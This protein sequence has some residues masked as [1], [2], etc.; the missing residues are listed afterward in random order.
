MKLFTKKLFKPLHIAGALLLLFLSAQSCKKSDNNTPI[1]TPAANITSIDGGDFVN[2]NK[3]TVSTI[4]TGLIAYWPLAGNAKD[5]SGNGNNGIQHGTTATA[6]H[7][8][9]AG[10]A[11]SFNG[12]SSYISVNDTAAPQL[13]NTSFSLNAWIYMPNYKYGSAGDLINAKSSAN[14]GWEWFIR[15]TTNTSE[16]DPAGGLNFQSGAAASATKSNIGVG[17]NGWHMVTNTYSLTNH[18]MKIYIDGVLN[19]TVSSIKPPAALSAASAQL[20]IGRQA[21]S[22]GAGKFFK[23][24]INEVR[25]YNRV[26]IPNEIQ[27]LYYVGT[28][29]TDGLV[30]YWPMVRTLGGRDLSGVDYSSISNK[31]NIATLYNARV[32]TDRFGNPYGALAFD[33]KTSRLVFE[34]GSYDVT[35]EGDP[36]VRTTINIWFKIGAYNAPI[37]YFGQSQASIFVNSQGKIDFNFGGQD[38]IG[39]RVASLQKWHMLTVVY[40]AGGGDLPGGGSFKTYLDIEPDILFSEV[41]DPTSSPIYN[42]SSLGGY[43]S[44]GARSMKGALSSFREYNRQLTDNEIVWLFES[45]N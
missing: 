14:D 34:N 39:S 38:F 29:P 32:T 43:P 20:Y 7:F 40:T 24:S 18:I 44:P 3:D 5:L 9:H 36:S 6:D 30:G 33:G 41:P 23:G 11:L 4:A 26:I 21:A 13:V 12:S 16:S 15:G 45:S 35:G 31:F 2:L 1:T 42:V 17:V 10:G 27:Y 37:M 19:K 25:I 22:V 28:V 8:G